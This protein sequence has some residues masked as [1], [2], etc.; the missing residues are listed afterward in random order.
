MQ[1]DL[2][3]L[4]THRIKYYVFRSMTSKGMRLA[5]QLVESVNFS[6]DMHAT[7]DLHPCRDWS[8]HSV[9]TLNKIGK[10]SPGVSQFE[11]PKA[12]PPTLRIPKRRTEGHCTYLSLEVAA[13]Q[14]E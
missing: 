1:D 4:S 14:F 10:E 12:F 3:Y 8:Q 7:A 2:R 11:A 5:L 13:G 9:D 6:Y